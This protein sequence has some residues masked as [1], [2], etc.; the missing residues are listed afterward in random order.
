[1]Q[2]HPEIVRPGR[3]VLE[4]WRRPNAGALLFYPGTMLAPGHYRLLLQAYCRAGFSVVGIHLPGHGERRAEA[5]FTFEELLEAGLEA[6]RWLQENGHEQ[7]AISGHSQG[8]ILG[9]AH[10]AASKRISAAFLISAVYP[11]LDMA[12]EL[13]RFAPFRAFRGALLNLL[14]RVAKVW[15]SLPVPLP[16]YLHLRKILAGRKLPLIMGSGRGRISYPLKFLVSL[17]RADIPRCCNCP[18]LLFS[19]ANDALFT[20]QLTE[21]VFDEIDAPFKELCWLQNGGHMAPLNSELAEFIAR[22]AAE[23]GASLQFPLTLGS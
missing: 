13:T 8:G 15:P 21:A 11:D 12:I 4:V 19:A 17:F 22:K 7:I 10:A 1:M 14:G 5:N 3:A 2:F 9:L 16:V 23:F 18:V 20:M 6:E